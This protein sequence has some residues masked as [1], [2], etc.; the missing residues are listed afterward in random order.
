MASYAVAGS[1]LLFGTSTKLFDL[2]ADVV[3]QWS[4]VGQVQTARQRRLL[5]SAGPLGLTA[6]AVSQGLT[7]RAQVRLSA[8]DVDVLLGAQ[9]VVMIS[10][11][12]PKRAVAFPAFVGA[13]SVR[14]P[15]QDVL[16]VDLEFRQSGPGAV[17]GA[18]VTSGSVTPPSGGYA[19]VAS[20][21]GVKA[22]SASTPV[23]SGGVGVAGAEWVADN[24]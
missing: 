7:V 21:S 12:E 20:T 1:R 19:Y 24:S 14:S 8:D 16:A 10:Q 11:T 6:D 23:P 5:D 17:E 9:G 13:R 4:L 18:A 3:A 15:A 22:V 2:T